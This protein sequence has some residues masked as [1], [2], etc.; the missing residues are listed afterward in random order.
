MSGD[1]KFYL[2]PVESRRSRRNRHTSLGPNESDAPRKAARVLGTIKALTREY[3]A[4]LDKHGG[5]IGAIGGRQVCDASTSDE[6]VLM[7]SLINQLAVIVS[8]TIEFL[9]EQCWRS[10]GDHY[11]MLLMEFSRCESQE[12]W[13]D[14]RRA[15][16]GMRAV[17]AKFDH[18]C[19]ELAQDGWEEFKR[20][21]LS[22]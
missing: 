16:S 14:A 1:S 9:Y 4:F 6:D 20:A 12:I 13:R 8:G 2:V 15:P 3:N 10:L 22:A 19:A 5:V 17:K 18:L 21:N 7:D 11:A